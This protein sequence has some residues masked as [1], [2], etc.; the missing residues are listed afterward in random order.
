MKTW[1]KEEC[2]TFLEASKKYQT[3]ITYWLALQFGLRLGEVQ[4]LLW[5]R[6]DFNNKVLHVEY[7]YYENKK[8]LSGLKTRS[9]YRSLPLSVQQ[10]ENLKEHKERQKVRTNIV[11]S[12]KDG[13]YLM[14]GNIRKT[15]QNICKNKNIKLITF[16]ELRHTH[17]TLFLE[18]NEHVKIV[19]Q[20]LRHA[21]A[22]TTLDIYSHVRPQVHQDSAQRFS[23]FFEG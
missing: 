2:R 3:H 20:R 11:A 5:D 21:K 23:D 17:A 4:G 19:Q 16:H 18:M 7:A 1:T 6:I 10:I 12:T 15:M 8:K 13:N 14:G 9:S 22:T